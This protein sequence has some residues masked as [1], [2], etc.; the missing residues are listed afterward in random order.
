MQIR[1]HLL[2]IHGSDKALGHGVD[3][4]NGIVVEH[5]NILQLLNEETYDSASG[6]TLSGWDRV[7]KSDFLQLVKPEVSTM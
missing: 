7:N 1:N 5:E 2:L 6:Q 3:H 4:Y